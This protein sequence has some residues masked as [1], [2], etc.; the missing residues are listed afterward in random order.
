MRLSR[1]E[2]AAK[3][4]KLSAEADRAQDN[5]ITAEKALR[6]SE[7]EI[8]KLDRAIKYQKY[9]IVGSIVE[10]AGLLDV[11]DPDKL[12][13]LLVREKRNLIR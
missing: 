6:K 5:A 11:Y 8:K 2:I 4:Q 3:L 9:I 12:L 1:E 10:K 13:L 7:N